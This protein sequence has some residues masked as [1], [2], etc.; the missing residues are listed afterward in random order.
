M[1]PTALSLPTLGLLGLV[2][3]C[4]SSTN[5]R[6]VAPDG[7][8]SPSGN[9]VE[10]SAKAICE[11]TNACA[12]ALITTLYGDVT[13]C[14]ARLAAGFTLG[15]GA[16]GSTASPV[17]TSACAQA[18]PGITCADLLSNQIAT[19]CRPVAG[20]LTDGAACA[21]DGQCATAHCKIALGQTCGTCAKRGAASAECGLA[22]DCE[23]GLT[24]AGGKCTSYGASG[25]AC[26]ANA[27]CRGDLVCRGGKCGTA[28]ATGEACAEGDGCDELHGVICSVAKKKCVPVSYGGG[29]AACGIVPS[30]VELCAS[31]GFCKGLEAPKY[32]G[33][34]V[35][36]AAD[37]E[38]CDLTNGPFCKPGAVCTSGKCVLPDPAKCR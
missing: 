36:A 3:G 26:S 5:G 13:A 16:N 27:P 32:Q 2:L 10:A 23:Y 38:S 17:A 14:T 29:N 31:S 34:C 33:T 4:S 11:R 7:G 1:Q 12:P 30:G 35:A 20:T 8:G 21:A 6:A 15:V 28:A 19:A 9:E 24:C 37:G 25:A 22:D 18:I